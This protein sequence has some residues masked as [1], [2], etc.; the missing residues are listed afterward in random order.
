MKK[1]SSDFRSDH[2][3]YT[4]QY[5]EHQPLDENGQVVDEESF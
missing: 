3:V 4:W 2:Y 5:L 1:T